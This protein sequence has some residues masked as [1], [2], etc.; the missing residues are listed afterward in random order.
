[1]YTLWSFS[2]SRT[3]S[4]SSV[5]W[6]PDSGATTSTMGWSFMRVNIGRLSVKRLKRSSL[7]NGL[8]IATRCCTATSMPP[9]LTPWMLNSGF[10]YSFD[11]R[12]INS[13]PADTR[14]AIGE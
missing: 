2:N 7:Q 1:M 13:N 12:C 6:W 3:V 14:G 10:S 9:T 11:S 8:V 5:E 4:R